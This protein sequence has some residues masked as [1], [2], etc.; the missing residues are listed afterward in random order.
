MYRMHIRTVHNFTR[1]LQPR[2]YLNVNKQYDSPCT[3]YNNWLAF[4]LFSRYFLKLTNKNFT[5][6]FVLRLHAC[7][8]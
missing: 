7:Q 2:R 6:I 4:S 3:K 8:Q 1:Q 5:L